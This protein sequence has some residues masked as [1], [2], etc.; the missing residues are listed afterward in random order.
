MKDSNNNPEDKVIDIDSKN[1]EKKLLKIVPRIV[2]GLFVLVVL[3]NSIYI[4][5]SKENG[6]VLRFGKIATIVTDAG[7][8]FKV[9][10]VDQVKKVNVKNIY[11]ME[12]GYRTQSGGNETS[13]AVYVDQ[14]EEATV[15]VDGANNNASI[16]L[17]DVI[18][19]YK[20][21]NPEEF[22]F[23]VDDIEGTLRL[24]L[25]DTIRT[26]M[27]SLTLDQAKTEKESINAAVK[28]LLQRKMTEYGAGIQ[29]E[30][31]LTQNVQFLPSVETAFQQKENANQYK[32][33]KIED[34][35]RYENT[36]I[37]K[38]KGEATQ[39]VEQ[40]NAYAAQ[41][42]AEA[43]AAVAQFNALYTEYKN[44]PQILKEKYYIEA[45]TAFFKNNTIIVDTTQDGD[46]Y[47]FYNFSDNNLVKE[48]ISSAP[49]N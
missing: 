12:Y 6:V 1:I 18:I 3:I 16:A 36:I 34:A 24:A 17:I 21:S 10:L 38:A 14:P 47:K 15:I 23:N 8:H 26:S 33:G 37:P 28:P 44:N 29:I 4:L 30:Q 46:L 11:N 7:P 13:E 22:L 43:N 20:V 42:V 19:K 2:I 49:N 39:L 35:E 9:P 32:N 31:V 45:M 48:Q 41:T 25:E 5:D 27:Q 40:A